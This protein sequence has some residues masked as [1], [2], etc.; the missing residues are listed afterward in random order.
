[1][2]LTSGMVFNISRYA[3]H[4]GPGIRTTVFLKGCPLNCWWCH[5]PESISPEPQLSFRPNRCIRCGACVEKCPNHALAMS[6]EGLTT[7]PKACLL[8]FACAAACP[9]DA[10]EVVG[11]AMSVAE[12][13]AEIAKDVP[14]YDESGGG[15]TFSGGEPLMQP[16]FLIELLDACGRLDLH[17]VVDTSGYAHHDTLL[18]VSRRTDLF[19]YDLKHMDSEVHR[20]Y[21]GVGNEL[22]LDNLS[23]LSSRDV[24]LRIRFPLIPG[25]NDDGE[26]VEKMAWFLRKLRRAPAV[27]VLPYH[28]VAVSKYTR[29][30]YNYR[31]AGISGPGSQQIQHVAATLSSHGLVVTIGGNEYERAYPPAPAIQP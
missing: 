27:D 13:M 26:N 25:I 20:K 24:D 9:A 30:G 22:I 31:L 28:D 8:S 5:N 3:I 6:D 2:R 18:E 17:R 4:D 15:V 7:D 11:R 19:L 14:F 21:T 23:A 16:E 10:R 29:F 1:M 12:V